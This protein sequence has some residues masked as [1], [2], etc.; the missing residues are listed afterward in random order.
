MISGTASFIVDILLKN[1]IIDNSSEDIYQYGF[2]IMISTILTFILAVTCGILLKCV[3]ASLIYFLIFAILRSICGGYHAK[4]YFQCNMIFIC[5][6][7]FVILAYKNVAIEQC[8]ELH[9]CIIIFAVLIT[10]FYAPVENKNKLLTIKQKRF[11]RILGTVLVILLA[12][13]SC[14]LK[15]K[16]NSG[17]SIL[18]DSTL[19]VVS[20]SMFVTNPMRGGERKCA[21]KQKRVS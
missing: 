4:T 11:F 7:L 15:I 2:E 21:K 9:Y 8:S 14:C 16:Y 13:T 18:I 5:V 20:V 3:T 19:L 1:K 6:T 10:I 12:M 17:Y